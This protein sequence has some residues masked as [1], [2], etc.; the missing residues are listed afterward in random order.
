[1]SL[2]L[3]VSLRDAIAAP[4]ALCFVLFISGCATPVR[5]HP[6]KPRLAAEHA[7]HITELKNWSLKAKLGVRTSKRGDSASVI[8]KHVNTEDSESN[9]IEIYGPFGSGR[10]E[11]DQDANGAALIDA[12]RR[13]MFGDSIESVLQQSTGLQLPF[14]AMQFW[15]RGLP[16]PEPS[17]GKTFDEFGR[18]TSVQQQGWSVRF[19]EYVNVQDYELPKRIKA[20][21]LP[22]TLRVYDQ[23]GNDIGDKMDVKLVIKYWQL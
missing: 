11:I 4:A 2:S 18:L 5:D 12:K 8:W 14:D 10:I 22:G 7:R 15:V 19:T 23:K 13:E 3:G 21:A 6:P 1:M 20:S 16:S 17:A 9:R